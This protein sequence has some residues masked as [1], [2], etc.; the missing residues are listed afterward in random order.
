[1]FPH[2]SKNRC[3]HRQ[4][5]APSIQQS[6]LFDYFDSHRHAAGPDDTVQPDL[7]DAADIPHVTHQRTPAISRRNKPSVTRR[8]ADTGIGQRCYQVGEPLLMRR[9]VAI[10]KR[11]DFTVR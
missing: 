9:R 8:D 10:A 6:H 4:G 3:I 5:M 11:D 1:M 2:L 7:Y